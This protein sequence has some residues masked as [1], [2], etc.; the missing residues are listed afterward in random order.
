MAPRPPRR[1]QGPPP[2]R[3]ASQRRGSQPI[4]QKYVLDY[5]PSV[6]TPPRVKNAFPAA[7]SREVDAQT[8]GIPARAVAA[9]RRDE[10]SQ[11]ALEAAQ[12][13]D[14][15]L[16]LPYQPTP[17]IN[18]PKP[19]TRA[20]GYDAA[21]Q[22]LRVRFRDGSV[23]GYYDVPASVWKNFRRVKSPGRAINRTLNGYAYARED[24][25]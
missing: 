3:P 20:A 21:T 5:R 1:R 4:Q 11:K 6:P 12:D 15:S 9:R 13:G 8:R 17:S 22:T 24:G 10:A 25:I 7:T 18:P 19:R 23:Y 14:D 2:P 16:L